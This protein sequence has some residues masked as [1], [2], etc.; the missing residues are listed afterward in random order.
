MIRYLVMPYRNVAAVSLFSI[1]FLSGRSGVAANESPYS[2]KSAAWFSRTKNT[3]AL[4]AQLGWC[5]QHN[6]DMSLHSCAIAKEAYVKIVGQCNAM[7]TKLFKSN[8]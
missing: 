3:E 4:H 1:L 5:A 8:Q 6:P 2:H 7:T